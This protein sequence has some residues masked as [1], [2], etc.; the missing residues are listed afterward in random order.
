MSRRMILG[1]SSWTSYHKALSVIKPK[2]VRR[3]YN[4]KPTDMHPIAFVD[5]E[6]LK[7]AFA[8]WWF[9][10]HW[11]RGGI[12]SWKAMTFNTRI[13]TAREKPVFRSAWENARC[14]VPATAYYEWTGPKDHKQPWVISVEQNEPVFFF[15][16][17]YSRL[18]EQRYTFT[19]LTREAMSE[20]ADLYNR[21][22]VILTTDQIERWLDGVDDDE[23]VLNNY[24]LG[25]SEKFRCHRVQPFGFRD[26]GPGLVRP[27]EIAQ[28]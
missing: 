2:P 14:V 21:M 19:I 16:G 15:A 4:I 17:L 11:Y 25:W 20:I 22:P 6:G 5:E 12:K 7:S 1:D 8:R 10:P 9:V 3:N 18:L 24:G 27:L 28:A 13:E 26:N 23:T